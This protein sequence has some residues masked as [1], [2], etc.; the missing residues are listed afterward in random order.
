M[1][2]NGSTKDSLKAKSIT[3]DVCENSFKYKSYFVRHKR[4]HTGE[5][6]YKCDICESK[7]S[8]KSNLVVHKRA[9]TG[10]KP[11]KC[12]SCDKSFTEKGN[13]KTYASSF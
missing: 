2:D 3:C 8:L 4:A 1:G 11:Y 12:D 7:F 6:P 13:N 5:K 10:E 9:Y